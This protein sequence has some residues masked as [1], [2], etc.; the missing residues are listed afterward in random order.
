MARWVRVLASCIVPVPDLTMLDVQ[1]DTYGRA[2]I[3]ST[4]RLCVYLVVD[5]DERV[6]YVGK[7]ERT[8]GTIADRFRDHHALT[9]DW[10]RVWILPLLEHLTPRE[11][12]DVEATLIRHFDPPCNV[13]WRRSR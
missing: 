5:H 1:R 13:Q 4:A 2:L 11:I 6:V 12:L 9:D 7:V 8:N 10:I 3:E